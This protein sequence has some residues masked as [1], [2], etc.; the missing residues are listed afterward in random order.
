[1]NYYLLVFAGIG[2]SLLAALAWLSF[3]GMHRATRADLGTRPEREYRHI[4]YL[5]HIK[6]AL[7]QADYEYLSAR[8]PT[9]LAKRVRKERRRI[10]LNYLSALRSEFERLQHMARV[11][12]VMSPEVAVAQ[13]LQGVRLNAEFSI[14]YRIIYFRLLSG[15]APVSAIN[16]LSNLI[17]SL[18]V[19]METAISSLG[20]S[21]ALAAELGSLHNGMN[22]G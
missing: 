13:E 2:L 8:G 5:P 22:A 15:I 3:A 12:V 16:N 17:S 18:T 19:R 21:A 6:Q 20:E 9:G 1:V 7:G 10:A 14:R 11:V 4:S